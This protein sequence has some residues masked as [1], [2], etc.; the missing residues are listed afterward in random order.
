MPEFDP[1][2]TVRNET[3]GSTVARRIRLASTSET[4]RKGLLGVSHLDDDSGL[5]IVP[6]EAVHTF[7]MRMSID[8]V[9]L[10]RSGRVRKLRPDLKPWRLGIDVRSHSVLELASGALAKSA[11]QVGDLLV[12]ERNS[13]GEE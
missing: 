3:R 13:K 10:D 11:T 5:W 12:F 4:R 6:C 9:F 8:T 2:Y 7:F 1:E